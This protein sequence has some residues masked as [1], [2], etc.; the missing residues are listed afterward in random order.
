GISPR[1]ELAQEARHAALVDS[2]VIPRDRLDG[3]RGLAIILSHQQK[4]RLHR[5][6]NRCC[7]EEVGPFGFARKRSGYR[8]EYRVVFSFRPTLQQPSSPAAARKCPPWRDRN[9]RPT[10]RTVGA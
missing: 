3:H 8:V 5:R 9:E 1:S 10:R 7:G 4:N 6:T 2:E